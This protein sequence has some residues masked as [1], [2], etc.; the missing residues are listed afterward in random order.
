MIGILMVQMR[1]FNHL[2][3]RPDLQGMAMQAVVD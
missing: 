2:N 1:E 3:I